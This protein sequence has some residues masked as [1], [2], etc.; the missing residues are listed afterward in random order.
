MHKWWQFNNHI[1]HGALEK[2]RSSSK[3]PLAFN[4]VFDVCVHNEHIHDLNGYGIATTLSRKV[5][6]SYEIQLRCPSKRHVHFCANCP[7]LCIPLQETW[8]MGVNKSKS[9]TSQGSTLPINQVTQLTIV[10][11]NLKLVGSLISPVWLCL[12]TESLVP[13]VP[14]PAL[15]NTK[16]CPTWAYPNPKVKFRIHPINSPSPSTTKQHVMSP[17][18]LAYLP[19]LPFEFAIMPSHSCP[20]LNT[21]QCLL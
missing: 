21:K 12:T 6:Q 7:L 3:F 10:P 1:S 20:L 9:M 19:S 4:M 17:C 13:I 15:F 2:Y 14:L 11:Q 8:V 18:P 16:Q 5:G